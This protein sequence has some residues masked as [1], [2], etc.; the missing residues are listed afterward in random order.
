[1]VEAALGHAVTEAGFAAAVSLG[2][3]VFSQKIFRR[4]GFSP[5][6]EIEYK[7]YK[8]RDGR[9][10]FNLDKMGIHSKGILYVKTL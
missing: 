10:L 3:S 9:K 8:R 4:V 2:L 6:V 7:D 1:M 5:A